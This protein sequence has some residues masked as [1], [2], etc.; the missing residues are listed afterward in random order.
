MSQFAAYTVSAEYATAPATAAAPTPAAGNSNDAAVMT[1]V[2]QI[3]NQLDVYAIALNNAKALPGAQPLQTATQA[4]SEAAESAAKACLESWSPALKELGP[5]LTLIASAISV[6]RGTRDKCE[7]ANEGY[8][9]LQGAMTAYNALCGGA[10]ISCKSKCEEA[11][12]A[13]AKFITDAKVISNQQNN[14]NSGLA[15]GILD[16]AENASYNYKSAINGC[17]EYQKNIVAATAGL[18]QFIV[19]MSKSKDC[20]DMTT[21]SGESECI[22]NPNLPQCVD[23]TKEQYHQHPTCICA[24]NPRAAGCKQASNDTITLPN[25]QGMSGNSDQAE[26][27]PS[28]FGATG[29]GSGFDRS[30]NPGSD[31]AGVGGSG[32]DGSMGGVGGMGAGTPSGGAKGIDGSTNGKG[33]N[34]NVVSGEGFG[35]G[36]GYQGGSFGS[37][38]DNPYSRFLP[39]FNQEKVRG[40]GDRTMASV[41]EQIT[42]SNGL[43]N[44]EKVKRRYLE[45]RYTLL[46]R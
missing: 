38:S 42:G 20:A 10:Q 26:G 27:T 14:P 3:K 32:F 30:G 37:T 28:T 23:C 35:G 24:Q 4:C 16:R 12:R 13:N 18:T 21:A 15:Q 46:S 9:L 11:S 5:H 29:L 33:L 43:S 44:F 36:G 34:A 2:E 22:K 39:N 25:Q 40:S 31:S 1:R 6:V 8:N 7:K 45:N 41:K 19:A 17:Q